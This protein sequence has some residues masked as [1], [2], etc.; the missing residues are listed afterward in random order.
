MGN[1]NL[2]ENIARSAAGTDICRSI[3]RGA[4]PELISSWAGRNPVKRLI[5]RFFSRSIIKSFTAEE[6][7]SSPPEN[8]GVVS[9]EARENFRRFIEAVDFGEL[10]ETLDRSSALSGPYI[11]MINEELWKYP[12]KVVCLLAMLPPLANTAFTAAKETASP[13]NRMAPDL[14]TDVILSLMRDIDMK[15]ISG[16]INE[17]SELVRKIHTGSA[18]IGEPGRP[19]IPEVFEEM[20]IELTDSINIPLLLKAGLMLGEI[21][22]Q[23]KA[24]ISGTVNSHQGLLAEKIMNSFRHSS[25]AAARMEKSLDSIEKNFNDRDLTDLIS[26]GIAEIDVQELAE[27]INRI[28]ELINRIHETDPD[29]IRGPLTQFFSSIDPYESAEA[30]RRTFDDIAESVKPAAPVILPPLL[31]GIGDIINS[32]R[33]ENP[34]EMDEALRT[35]KEAMK[36]GGGVI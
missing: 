31:K 21:K 18:L 20:S 4:A 23:I 36:G 25:S 17:L 13:L 14:L 28:C 30:I 10:K 15:K 8:E 34:H 26:A 7:G 9:E 22:E 1:K 27:N 19:A 29:I 35:L 12:A 32:A 2:I 6:T 24:S 16:L 33:D 5:S 11:K 3:V